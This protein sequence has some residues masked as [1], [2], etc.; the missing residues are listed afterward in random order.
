MSIDLEMSTPISRRQLFRVGLGDLRSLVTTESAGEAPPVYRPPGAGR[1]EAAFLQSCQRCGACVAACP[2]DVI[3]TFGPASGILEGTPYLV[4]E[5]DPCRWCPEMPCIESC[6]SGSL[7]HGES[8]GVPPVAKV[9]LDLDACLTS[10]GILCDTCSHFCP[11]SIGAIRMVRRVPVLD[12]DRCVG[13]GMCVHYCESEK[14]PF[15]LE[16]LP[17]PL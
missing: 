7:A 9:R 16:P 13:C 17:E 4:P 11:E 14:Q 10:E 1:D 5:T 6:P 2:Y 3:K 12:T 8:G 15:S